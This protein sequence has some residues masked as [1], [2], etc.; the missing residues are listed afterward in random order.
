MLGGMDM[1]GEGRMNHFTWYVVSTFSCCLA[2]G[3]ATQSWAW[4]LAVFS[5]SW[6][7]KNAVMAGYIEGRARYRIEGELGKDS[8]L[9]PRPDRA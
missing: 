3:L 8:L 2:V 6:A 4:A 9:H 5:I 1:D 7:I